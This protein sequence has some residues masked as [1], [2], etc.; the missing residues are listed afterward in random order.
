MVF[1]DKKAK[2]TFNTSQN[3]DVRKVNQLRISDTAWKRRMTE[4]G[5]LSVNSQGEREGGA[6]EEEL[7]GGS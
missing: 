5:M 7:W 2:V 6:L 1:G 4:K 3:C